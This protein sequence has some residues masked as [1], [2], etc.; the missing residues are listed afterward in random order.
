MDDAGGIYE[1]VFPYSRLPSQCRVS[2][3]DVP[4]SWRSGGR[5]DAREY[6]RAAGSGRLRSWLV[7]EN[8]RPRTDVSRKTFR[9]ILRTD[10]MNFG[11]LRELQP[12]PWIGLRQGQAESVL[13]SNGSP[14]RPR[15]GLWQG[16]PEPVLLSSA[17]QPSREQLTLIRVFAERRGPRYE[18]GYDAVRRFAQGWSQS[19][20][21]VRSVPMCR[22]TGHRA[23][24]ADPTGAT[25][26]Y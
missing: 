11:Y 25:R 5:D 6:D 26:S 22:S 1:S 16:R 9:M 2:A 14:P 18:G 10:A 15:I 21:V 7:G 23:R 20:G 17:N 8:G 4:F 13:S 24:P 3:P 12:L 19:R